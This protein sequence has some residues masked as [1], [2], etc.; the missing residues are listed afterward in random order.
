MRMW[1]YR[2]ITLLRK[3]NKKGSLI[4]PCD[5]PPFDFSK[6]LDAQ[7]RKHWHIHCAKPF[8]NPKKDIEYLGRYI[9]RAPIA[10]SRLTH[11]NGDDVM[12]KF[13]PL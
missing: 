7:Y 13:L 9:K 12:F 4:F 5:I 11:Y 10:N 6:I 8:T 1:R 3:E 2:I